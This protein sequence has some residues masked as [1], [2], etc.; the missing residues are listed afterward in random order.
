ME[1]IECIIQQESSVKL[2]LVL[3]SVRLEL[4]LKNIVCKNDTIAKEVIQCV[5]IHACVFL[6]V[7][8]CACVRARARACACVCV[9]V[10]AC[11][12]TILKGIFHTMQDT[13]LT[14]QYFSTLFHKWYNL[15]KNYRA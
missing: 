11:V 12:R 3:Y 6:Y 1:L 9:C 10:R 4:V 8:V 5:C 15:K 2:I 7:C 13:C 14:L